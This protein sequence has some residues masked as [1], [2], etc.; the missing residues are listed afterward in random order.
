M[1]SIGL[2]GGIAS[3]KSTVIGALQ[4][5][6]ATVLDA[7]LVA[8]KLMEPGQIIWQQII[9]HFG[10]AVLTPARQIDRRILGAIIFADE[11]QRQLLNSISHPFILNTLQEEITRR[12][13]LNPDTLIFTE[14]PLLFEIGWEDHFAEV[15]TVWV[16]DL[17]Q[18]TRLMSRDDLDEAAARARI[19]SQMSLREKAAKSHRVIDNSGSREKTIAQVQAFFRDL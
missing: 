9:E 13:R 7:D 3:G 12:E 10:S 11:K 14:I 6:G 15:W 16:D 19:A 1:K 4:A 5:L 2:T 18:L 17:T 8:H